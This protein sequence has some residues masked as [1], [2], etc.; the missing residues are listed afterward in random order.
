MPRGCQ[1][2]GPFCFLSSMWVCPA[3]P[4][5]AGEGMEEEIPLL[6]KSEVQHIRIYP[7]LNCGNMAS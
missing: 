5:Q 6:S 2:T 3:S 1:E 7:V 4:L